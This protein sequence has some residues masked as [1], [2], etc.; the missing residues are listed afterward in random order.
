MEIDTAAYRLAE[1]GHVTRLAVFRHLVRCGR[2]GCRVG[3]LQQMLNV[4][5]STLSH[6][7]GRLIDAGLVSQI[8]EGRVLRCKPVFSALDETLGFL[9]DECC[10][11]S[12]GSSDSSS[13]SG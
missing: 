10:A 7:L 13:K 5:A 4:P 9:T 1:L 2:D 8:R 11:G 6:H 12:C 3:D